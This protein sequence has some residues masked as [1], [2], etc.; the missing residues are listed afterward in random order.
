MGKMVMEIKN[1]SKWPKSY[2]FVSST[3][4]VSQLHCT[5]ASYPAG[6]LFSAQL[7]VDIEYKIDCCHTLVHDIIRDVITVLLIRFIFVF[8]I[9][10]VMP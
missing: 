2:V 6:L 7:A 3:K 9:T 4:A 10:F 1:K 5:T 8:L